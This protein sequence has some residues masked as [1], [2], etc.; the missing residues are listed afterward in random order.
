M[1]TMRDFVFEWNVDTIVSSAFYLE[2][3]FCYDFIEINIVSSTLHPR[4]GKDGVVAI[5]DVQ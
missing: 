4:V 1:Y 5:F 2:C 3:H